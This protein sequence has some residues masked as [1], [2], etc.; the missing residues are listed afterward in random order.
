MVIE[1][2]ILRNYPDGPVVGEIIMS[3]WLESV[4]V[5]LWIGR[6]GDM[7]FGLSRAVNGKKM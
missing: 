1:A 5:R 2:L 3:D 7:Y 6:G 4:L